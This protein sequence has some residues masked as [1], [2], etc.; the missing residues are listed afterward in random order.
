MRVEKCKNDVF[1][2]IE[3]YVKIS[4]PVRGLISFKMEEFQKKCLQRI[5]NNNYNIICKCRDSGVD[6]VAAS[7]CVWRFLFLN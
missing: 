3:N 4:H 6:I 2:F 5:I 7:Y 1:Y